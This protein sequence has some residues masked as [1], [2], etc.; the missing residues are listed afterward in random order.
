M[1]IMKR[2]FAAALAAMVALA[3]FSGFAMATPAEVTVR[4]EGKSGTLFDRVIRTD[5]HDVRSASDTATR[6]CD[7][8]NLSAN[9]EPGPTSTAAS[10]DAMTINGTDFDAEWYD[11]FEDYFIQRWGPD[12]EDNDNGWWWGILVNREFTPVGGCQYRLVDGDE[13]LWVYEAFNGRPFL[14][15]DGPDKAVVGQPVELE[16]TDFHDSAY[17]GATVSGLTAAAAPVDSS[18]TV[19]GSSGADGTA[20]V[21][22][23]GPGWKRLK[24]SDPG[25]GPIADAVPSNSIDICVELV[26]GSGCTGAAPSQIPA[27]VGTAPA[28]EVTEPG[29]EPEPTCETDSSLCPTPDPTCETD[30]SLCPT[31]DPTCETDPLLCPGPDPVVK[32]KLRFTR[33]NLGPK[34]VKPGGSVRTKVTIRNLGD[35]VAANLKVCLKPVAKRKPATGLRVN[36]NCRRPRSLQA[37]ARRGLFFQVKAGRSARGGKAS[38]RLT[39]TADGAPSLAKTLR[40]GVKR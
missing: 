2:F 18:V 16:V 5:G 31:P 13:V 34:R 17:E 8:T 35:G 28:V 30:R 36:R 12:G 24:A 19:P 10:V 21:T 38:L 6:K 4:I 9:P 14:S 22:F 27:E 23:N 15:L 25:P 40:F 7:G 3:V 1:R 29:T 20:S 26:V 37:G 39:A 32:P 33:I 11:G